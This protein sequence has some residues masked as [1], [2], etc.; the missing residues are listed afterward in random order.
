M[1]SRLEAISR[2]EAKRTDKE[3]HKSL[4]V[5]EWP[6]LAQSGQSINVPRELQ[7]GQS[8]LSGEAH[9]LGIC[10]HAGLGLDEIVI[11]LDR[12]HAEIEV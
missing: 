10:L 1:L 2:C 8:A 11:V 7:I 4:S 12:L 9:K 6:L 3:W 5:V